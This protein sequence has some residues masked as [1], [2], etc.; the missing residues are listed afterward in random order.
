MKTKKNVLTN[1]CSR[2]PQLLLWVKAAV[3]VVVVAVFVSGS[4]M[5]RRHWWR[6][7]SSSVAV[8]VVVDD[9]AANC[10]LV[11]WLVWL[12]LL[13]L[14]DL[15]HCCCS[16]RQWAKQMASPVPAAVDDGDGN[17]R[18]PIALPS[19]SWKWKSQLFC[20]LYFKLYLLLEKERLFCALQI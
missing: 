11:M 15:C 9:G 1:P 8:S 5:C 13:L 14:L 10:H 7:H 20:W 16:N 3:N 19:K 2:A 17:T 18:V 6:L 4:T 12:P